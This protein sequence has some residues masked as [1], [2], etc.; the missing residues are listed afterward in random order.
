MKA[1]MGGA[2]IGSLAALTIQESDNVGTAAVGKRQRALLIPRSV[3]DIPA[4]DDIVHGLNY[5]DWGI[6]LVRLGLNLH[7][8]QPGSYEWGKFV[9]P[10]NLNKTWIKGCYGIQA[11]GSLLTF[12]LTFISVNRGPYDDLAI[13]SI[14]SST[15]GTM[16]AYKAFDFRSPIVTAVVILVKFGTGMGGNLLII[17]SA[18]AENLAIDAG[19][20]TAS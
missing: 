20:E 18:S 13:S 8:S 3:N 17:K 7:G 19:R 1:F 14:L 10:G 9:A 4:I 6:T 5:F 2:S 12:I 11:V 15:Q 16:N